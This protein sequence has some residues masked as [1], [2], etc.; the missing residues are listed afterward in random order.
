LCR[1]ADNEGP[2]RLVGELQ[3]LEVNAGRRFAPSSEL[4]ETAQ[5]GGFYRRA[6]AK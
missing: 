4:I 1:W 6:A 3:R 2:F 5:A